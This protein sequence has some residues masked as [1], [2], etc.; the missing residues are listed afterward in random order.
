MTHIPKGDLTLMLEMIDAPVAPPMDPPA[1]RE[2]APP[3]PTWWVAK[4]GTPMTRHVTHK[5]R[6]TKTACGLSLSRFRAATAD[7]AA[8]LGVCAFCAPAGKAKKVR[9]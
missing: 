1:P 3:A 5:H 6:P 9:R 8:H 7:E 4:K 2:A